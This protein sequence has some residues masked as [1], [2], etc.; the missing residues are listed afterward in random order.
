M[1]LEITAGLTS[2]GTSEPLANPLD[3]EHFGRVVD[4][5]KDRLVT[6]VTRLTGDRDRA[7][8]VAQE[9][10]VRAYRNRS[11]YRDDGTLAAYL[12][13][14]A[15]NLVRDGA[16]RRKRWARLRPLLGGQGDADV[17]EPAPRPAP[18]PERCLEADEVRRQ[19]TRAIASLDLRF[20][21][22]LVLREIEELS[23]REIAEVLDCREGTVKSR[24][25]TA[26]AQLKE[27]LTP[28]WTGRSADD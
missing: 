28:Y 24:L 22:P 25:H 1:T 23:Y 5:Y 7:E 12:Y 14:I 11:R 4:D 3:R 27:K 21:A 13:R 8:D 10:F 2:S 26:R 9:T 16:R 6:Y 18:D 17:V 15:T 19:V 20:R